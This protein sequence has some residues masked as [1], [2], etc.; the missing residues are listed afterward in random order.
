MFWLLNLQFFPEDK[1]DNIGQ[2]K[3]KW[4]GRKTKTGWY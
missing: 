4:A 3:K 1:C 2:V